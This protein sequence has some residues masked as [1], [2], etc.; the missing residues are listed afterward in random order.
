MKAGSQLD[1]IFL[2]Q[3]FPATT[4]AFPSNCYKNS[5]TQL[6]APKAAFHYG[7]WKRCQ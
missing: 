4:P 1:G 6:A 7:E 5:E 2:W 3:N